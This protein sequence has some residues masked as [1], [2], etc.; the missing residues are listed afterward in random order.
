MQGGSELAKCSS[1]H[2]RGQ[3]WD[4]G[5]EQPPVSIHLSLCTACVCPSIYFHMFPLSV[6]L[7]PYSLCVAV[8]PSVPYTHPVSVHL[9]S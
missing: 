7:F 6:H 4:L 2:E 1:S 8:H 9:S 5:R 3:D